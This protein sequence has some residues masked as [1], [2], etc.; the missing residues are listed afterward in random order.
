MPGSGHLRRRTAVPE[1]RRTPQEQRATQGPA[2]HRCTSPQP[3]PSPFPAGGAL[4]RPCP[5]GPWADTVGSA[6]GGHRTS[7]LGKSTCGPSL[8]LPASGISI[9]S[10]L[11]LGT[12]DTLW[13]VP[14]WPPDP[15]TSRLSGSCSLAWFG[16]WELGPGGV[17]MGNAAGLVGS[18]VKYGA[19]GSR[20]CWGGCCHSRGLF[21]SGSVP[22]KNPLPRPE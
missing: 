8:G 15:V 17:N 20:C 5:H 11:P 16:E 22:S 9:A 3:S 18:E 12:P 4:P 21:L 6:P 10:L 2:S 7:A 14:T 13:L 1:H 19:R